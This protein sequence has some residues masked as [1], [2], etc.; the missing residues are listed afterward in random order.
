M[1]SNRPRAAAAAA[2]TGQ[3]GAAGPRSSQGTGRRAA[4]VVPVSPP[5]RDE[6]APVSG[7]KAGGPTASFCLGGGGGELG[8]ALRALP[9]RAGPLPAF[10]GVISSGISASSLQGRRWQRCD[11]WRRLL[12]LPGLQNRRVTLAILSA[13]VKLWP[14][15]VGE[16]VS[17]GFL[18]S[19]HIRT[20]V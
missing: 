19:T 15:A 17:L 16:A 4:A 5:R 14:G 2:P 10:P 9:D 20:A 12:G 18:P 8:S 6:R 3:S 1:A 11:G 13:Q 7:V